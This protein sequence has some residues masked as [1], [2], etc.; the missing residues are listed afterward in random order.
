MPESAGARKK[1]SGRRV[2]Y[3]VGY[4]LTA[5]LLLAITAAL[6]IVVLP[7]RYALV[8][9]LRES[10]ISFPTSVDAVAFPMA[11]HEPLITPP[12]PPVER[13]PGPSERIWATVDSLLSIGD[14]DAAIAR[15]EEHLEAHP[16]DLAIRRERARTLANAGRPAAARA[17]FEDLVRR[18]DAR[19]DR[20]SISP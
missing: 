8:A 15:M 17:A 16:D 5:G 18:A 9:E 3:W 20:L 11:E 19:A 7:S 12:P 10:G 13:E 1:G 4:G 6:V 14:L 2:P